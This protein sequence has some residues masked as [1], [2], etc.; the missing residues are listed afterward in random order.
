MGTG[1]TLLMCVFAWLSK[2]NVYTNFSTFNFNKKV[3]KFS[4]KYVLDETINKCDVFL[5]EIYMY[6]DSRKFMSDMNT[7]MSTFAFQS[8]K[9]SINM[10][11]SSQL[12]R[13]FD[14][15]MRLMLDNVIECEVFKSTKKISL[16]NK[17]G[18][19]GFKYTIYTDVNNPN[20]SK[21]KELFLKWEQAKF[22]FDKYDTY[23][24]IKTKTFNNLKKNVTAD[25][26]TDLEINHIAKQSIDYLTKRK[27]KINKKNI[28]VFCNKNDYSTRK[29]FIDSLYSDV[30]IL[31]A[32]QKI[33]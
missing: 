8:R 2:R 22:F 14:V 23:E 18:I 9:L 24:L 1:K 30:I 15:R 33:S 25:E 27:L 13:T 29:S 28:W 3:D 12:I 19:I 31:Q 7:L 26:Y 32:E 17:D 10:Y 4:V 5:D 11:L 6:I 16:T 20:C 21:P